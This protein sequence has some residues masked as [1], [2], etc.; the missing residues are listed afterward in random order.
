MRGWVYVISNSA[1]PGLVK[2]GFSTKDPNSRAEE[3]DHTG[4]PQPYIVEYDMLI[5]EPR[6][7]EQETHKRL[8]SYSAGKEWFRCSVQ[9]AVSAIQQ[10][11]KGRA[12]L[13]NLKDGNGVLENSAEAVKRVRIR[14]AAEQGDASEQ[15]RL[16]ILYHGGHGVPQDY[17]EAAKW[18][19]KAAE[20]GDADAQ[21]N[22]GNMYSK[23]QGVPQD[24]VEAVK[25][26]RKV[27]EQGN[28]TAQNDLGL[29]YYKGQ[30]VP[31]DYV[32]AAEWFR[33]AAEQ[34]D[35]TAQ[36]S[37]GEFD[38]LVLTFVSGARAAIAR[39]NK[40]TEAVIVN[41]RPKLKDV[42]R[43]QFDDVI[44]AAKSRGL[45]RVREDGG[46]TIYEPLKQ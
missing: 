13:E 30:G 7:I 45:I 32:E 4:S 5:D 46:R 19:R 10:V 33:K 15:N 3:L 40:P 27:A 26:Y 2:V 35:V 25:W 36:I 41:C 9:E 24:Y 28:V 17:A 22:L 23:G 20:Q 43:R 44:N 31:Q 18:F 12:I 34:G 11:S 1:M 39:G 29:M 8:S 16:G 42:V 6:D 37:A 14:I 38:S 21:L